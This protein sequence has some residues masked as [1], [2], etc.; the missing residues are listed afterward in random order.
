MVLRVPLESFPATVKR[1]LSCEQAYVM[2][3][4]TG[5]IVTSAD[6]KGAS[7][8]VCYAP[9]S[10]EETTKQL[11]EQGMEVFLGTW[12]VE[13]ATTAEACEAYVAAVAYSSDE[14]KPGL[15]MDA[16]PEHPTLASVMR[17]MYDEFIATG[18]VPEDVSLEEFIRLA[19]PNVVIL[20][21]SQVGKFVQA[22]L[23]C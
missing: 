3:Q 5:S 12:S 2:P 7:L 19:N 9:T 17:A 6:H 11:E 4:G 22:K 10:V 13:D 20:S 1:L 15:W 8:V 23:E 21:P 16:F 18:E 14:A